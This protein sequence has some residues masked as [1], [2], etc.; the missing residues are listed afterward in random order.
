MTV[1]NCTALAVVFLFSV[2]MNSARA[3]N[4]PQAPAAASEPAV[5]ESKIESPAPDATAIVAQ[6]PA[7]PNAQVLENIKVYPCF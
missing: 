1:E 7:G 4:T 5:A 3:E 2:A 6:A